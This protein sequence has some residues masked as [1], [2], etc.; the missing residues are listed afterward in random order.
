MDINSKLIEWSKEG[1]CPQL[2]YD[3]N[4]HWAV[5]F[6][7]FGPASGGQ[8]TVFYD[9]VIW[10]DTPLEAV[11]AVKLEGEVSPW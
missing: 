11:E 3:D 9:G 5:S 1:Y 4:G 6:D 10:K 2:M 7:S 8:E